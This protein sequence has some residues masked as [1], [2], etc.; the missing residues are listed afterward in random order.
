MS[1]SMINPDYRALGRIVVQWGPGFDKVQ[2]RIIASLRESAAAG[3]T[4]N[5]AVKAALAAIGAEAEWKDG[6]FLIYR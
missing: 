5:E 4:E 6:K 1:Q 3:A 2:E